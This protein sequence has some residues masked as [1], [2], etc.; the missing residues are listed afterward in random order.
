LTLAVVVPAIAGCG[1][2]AG[3]HST[4]GARIVHFTLHSRFVHAELH[5]IRVVPRRHGDWL[6]VLLHGKGGGPTQF[7]S[8]P[9]F[10][11]LEA[12][13]GQP[14]V[15]LLLDGGTTAIGTTAPTARGGRWCWTRRSRNA[16]E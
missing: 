8:Q 14:P 12:L 2:G 4:R 10:D 3:Y 13:G 9:F 1:G 15:V 7:L 16:D 6:L 5:E 11:T